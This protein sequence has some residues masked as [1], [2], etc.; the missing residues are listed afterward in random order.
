MSKIMEDLI[1]DAKK[2]IAL[3]ILQDGKLEKGEIAR[4]C[5][6]TLEQVK[7]LSKMQTA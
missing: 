3:K 2:E 7:E 5:S 1:E 6:L 4:Y